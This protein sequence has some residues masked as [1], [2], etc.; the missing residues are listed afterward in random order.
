MIAVFRYLIGLDFFFFLA[1]HQKEEL[2]VMNGSYTESNLGSML[3]WRE[4]QRQRERERQ[5]EL[6]D[7]M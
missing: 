5:R 1:W 7:H 6:E 4:K 2:G 3:G